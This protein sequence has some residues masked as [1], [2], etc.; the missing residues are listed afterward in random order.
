MKESYAFIEL[1]MQYNRLIL[2]HSEVIEIF[3]DDVRPTFGNLLG[4]SNFEDNRGIQKIR[5][6]ADAIT[7][8]VKETDFAKKWLEQIEDLQKLFYRIESCKNEPNKFE[9]AK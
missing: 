2:S 1:V 6:I 4:V 5:C 3:T 7:A 9:E 8:A